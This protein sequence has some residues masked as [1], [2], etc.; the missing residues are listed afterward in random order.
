[1]AEAVTKS[2]A[3]AGWRGADLHAEPP[4]KTGGRGSSC[5]SEKGGRGW[6]EVRAKPRGFVGKL[7]PTPATLGY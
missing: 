1:M 3:K 2:P 5:D 4:V 6:S 7:S